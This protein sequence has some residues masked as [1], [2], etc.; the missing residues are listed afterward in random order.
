MVPHLKQVLRVLDQ[1]EASYDKINTCEG[2]KNPT[3]DRP[4]DR[5]TEVASCLPSQ[6]GGNGPPGMVTEAGAPNPA[7]PRIPDITRWACS[8]SKKKKEKRSLIF[9]FPGPPAVSPS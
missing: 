1:A 6:P 3:T 7:T 4:S 2:E 5:L 8:N 9:F